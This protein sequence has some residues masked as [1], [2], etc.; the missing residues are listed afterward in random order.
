MLFGDPRLPAHF[1]SKVHVNPETECWEWTAST[2]ADGYGQWHPGEAWRKSKSI[3]A[4]KI[5]YE[6]LIGPVPEELHLDHVV[7]QVR[8]CVNPDHLEPVPPLVNV[9]RSAVAN[10]NRTVCRSGKH[11]LT[12][13]GALRKT[14]QGERCQGCYEDG[15]RKSNARRRDRRV[16]AGERL[17]AP[18]N[19]T[20]CPK[21]HP[22][23]G[24]NLVIKENGARGCRECIYARNRA[25][26]RKRKQQEI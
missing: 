15:Y 17:V 6:N 14:N 12:L 20:H 22:Y 9:L 11:D 18:K 4:H 10:A 8:R 21:G 1:W 5:A 13:P 25:A 16:A 7:C 24:S 19:R 23:E 3:S 26:Y 2:L